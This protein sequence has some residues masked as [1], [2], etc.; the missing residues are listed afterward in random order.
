MS[1]TTASSMVESLAL[2]A[3]KTTATGSPPRSPARCSLEPCLP[4]STGFAPVRSPFDRPQAEGVHADAVQVDPSGRAEVVQQHDLELVEHPS[5]GPL[6]QPPPAG[7]GRAAAQLPGGQQRP[8]S[9]RAGHEDQRRHT[10]AVGHAAGHAAAGTRWAG[11][12]SGWMRCHSASGRRRSTRLVM[13]RASSSG[14]MCSSRPTGRSGMSTKPVVAGKVRRSG[15]AEWVPSCQI[16]WLPTRR[17][18]RFWPP[19]TNRRAERPPTPRES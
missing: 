16:L 9:R 15:V 19:R 2:A 13:H 1:S 4:R 7:G 17:V 11:G 10:V 14:P 6:V 3:L 18:E 12:R 5:A 8:R